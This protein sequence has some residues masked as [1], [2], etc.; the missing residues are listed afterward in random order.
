[1]KRVLISGSTGLVGSTLTENLAQWGNHVVPLVRSYE[2]N[3]IFWDPDLQRIDANQLEGFD[4]VIHLAGE[5]IAN[6]RWNEEKKKRIHDSRVIGT[7]VLS[8]AL[9]TLK[10]PPKLLICASAVGF[11]GDRGETLLSEESAPGSGF[12]AEVVKGWEAATLPARS[13]GI[14]VV[15]L[16]F[17]IVLSSKGGALAKMLTPFQMGLGGVI[18]TGEQYMSWIGIDDVVGVVEHVMECKKLDGPINV[19]SP[20]PVTNRVF[21][22]T[23]GKVL[24]RPT[25]LPMPLFAARLAFGEMVDEVMLASTRMTPTKLIETGYV[26]RYPQLEK[27]FEVAVRSSH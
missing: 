18:G 19:V 12:L 13:N 24:R 20:I 15:H 5:P 25:I 1:M 26:F 8:E 11:Y 22:K 16:R 7:R 27:A 21:T 6:A 10:K 17:G 9:A 23:L 3:G 4:T 14:R 2:E